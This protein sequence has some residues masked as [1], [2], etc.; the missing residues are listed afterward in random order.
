[1]LRL[2]G[3]LTSSLD[4]KDAIDIAEKKQGPLVWH[5]DLA[6]FKGLKRGLT[7]HGDF[8][9][10][11]LALDHFKN[12]IWQRFKDK[13]ERVVLYQGPLD[14]CD[15]FPWDSIQE[16][17][18]HQSGL[19]TR[20]YC[21]TACAEY[22]Q[23]LVQKM[24]DEMTLA[25]Q[26]DA[27]SIVDS[28]EKALLLN[29]ELFSRFKLEVVGGDPWVASAEAALCLPLSPASREAVCCIPEKCRLIPESALVY[30]WDGLERLYYDPHALNTL[31]VRKL[32]GFAAAGGELIALK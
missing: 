32:H 13:T 28:Y 15:L 21:L 10:L 16:K 17:N 27:N 1:M 31:A 29:P 22:L 20:R 5:L 25:L 2:D 30:S 8:H 3:S 7:H 23:L 24:P 26:F 18:F 6:L 11:M 19:S 12:A 9:G 14:V 4:W